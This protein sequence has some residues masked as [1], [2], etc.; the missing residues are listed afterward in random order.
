MGLISAELTRYEAEKVQVAQLRKQT[1]VIARFSTGQASGLTQPDP[2]S[3]IAIGG[4]VSASRAITTVRPSNACKL[5]CTIFTRIPDQ[6]APL[7][8]W[9]VGDLKYP[10]NVLNY[11]NPKGK[12]KKKTVPMLRTAIAQTLARCEVA[13]IV[14]HSGA[15]GHVQSTT[16]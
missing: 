1:A 11:L 4:L 8:A 14:R 9:N 3:C 5:H 13:L 7:M 6:K 15:R 10:L 16:A 2:I 12:Q